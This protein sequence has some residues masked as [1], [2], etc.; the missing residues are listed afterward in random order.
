MQ[1][2]IKSVHPPQLCPSANAK[3]REMVVQGMPQLPALAESLG[4]GVITINIYGGD[5]ELLMVVESKDI[6][7]VR[8]FTRVSGLYQWNTVN[9]SATYGPEEAMKSLEGMDPIF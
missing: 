4:L 8:E 2:V 6:E 3:I 9:V 7:S 5:H 1:Y